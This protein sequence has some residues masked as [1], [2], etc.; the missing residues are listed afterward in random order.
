LLV[1]AVAQSSGVGRTKQFRLQF[2]AEQ[3]QRWNGPDRQRQGIP[4]AG[5]RGHQYVRSN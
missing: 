2:P 3:Q 4:G 1:T 5:R